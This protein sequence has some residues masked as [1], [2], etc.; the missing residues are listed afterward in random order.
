MN[1]VEWKAFCLKK[2]AHHRNM[3]ASFDGVNYQCSTLPDKEKAEII[4]SAQDYGKLL[5]AL[6]FI[7]ETTTDGSA[8]NTSVKELKNTLLTSTQVNL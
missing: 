4:L 8:G 6:D 2:I 7:I 3:L 5:G 1:E